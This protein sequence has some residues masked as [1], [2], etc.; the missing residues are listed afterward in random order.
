MIF[1]FKLFL[2]L[3]L[4][5][6]IGV[7]VI[8]VLLNFELNWQVVLYLLTVLIVYVG[9]L[10]IVFAKTSKKAKFIYVIL[11]MI[12]MSMSRMLPYIKHAI[13]V[14]ACIDSGICSEKKCK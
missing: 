12:F 1:I 14:D 13:D 4:T 2:C 3:L 11:F 5:P 8:I 10:Y 7:G 6:I 9:M